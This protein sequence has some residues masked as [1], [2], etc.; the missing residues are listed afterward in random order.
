MGITTRSHHV[1]FLETERTHFS[2]I[3]S[4]QTNSGGGRSEV[5]EGAE[6]EGWSQRGVNYRVGR[7]GSGTRGQLKKKKRPKVAINFNEAP[8]R[9]D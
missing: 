7:G 1:L 6:S 4:R 3:N 5:G 2:P 8:S 9:S